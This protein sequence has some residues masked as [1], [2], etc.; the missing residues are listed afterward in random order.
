VNEPDQQQRQR[1]RRYVVARARDIP[2]D[3]K[4]IVEVGGRQ[5]GIYHVKGAFHALLNRC[6]HLGGPLC[7]GQVVPEIISAE[8]GDLRRNG[9]RLF[10]TC[11]WHNWEFEMKSGQSYWNPGGLRARPFPV[12]VQTGEVLC[13]ALGDGSAERVKG[14]FKAEVIP[15]SQEN[16]YLVVTLRPTAESPSGP[17]PQLAGVRK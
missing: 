15:L 12:D 11:P 5:I 13:A 1:P 16:E 14:P 8:P 7:E 6:P 10:V 2:E 9:D 17:P 3:G 4:V